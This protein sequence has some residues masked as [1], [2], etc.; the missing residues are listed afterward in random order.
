MS[1]DAAIHDAVQSAIAPLVR[2]IRDL[3]QK[4]EPPQEWL[5]VADA[6]KHFKVSTSTIRRWIKEGRIEAKGSAKRRQVRL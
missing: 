3:R 2:E 1:I 5:N 6:A 4:I